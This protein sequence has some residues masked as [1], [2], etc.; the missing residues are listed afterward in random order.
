M[1]LT[2]PQSIIC[3]CQPIPAII[4]RLIPVGI[5]MVVLAFIGMWLFFTNLDFH[6]IWKVWAIII[7]FAI[8]GGAWLCLILA[9]LFFG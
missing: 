4:F 8:H 6:R 9:L 7:I 3:D 1:S 2:I 5:L